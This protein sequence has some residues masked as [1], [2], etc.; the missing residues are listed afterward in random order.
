MAVSIIFASQ[1]VWPPV[2]L[3]A[4]VMS[5]YF[6]LAG[7]VKRLVLPKIHFIQLRTK[8]CTIC[9]VESTRRTESTSVQTDIQL[10]SF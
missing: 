2:L 7:L 1:Q 5:A 6:Y 8:R 10:G 9:R 3:T 4:A